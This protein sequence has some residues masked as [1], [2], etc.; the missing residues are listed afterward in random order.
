MLSRYSKRRVMEDS[1]YIQQMRP[2][3]R[4]TLVVEIVSTIKKVDEAHR[5]K[6]MDLPGRGVS[7]DPQP[8]LANKS[9]SY[10]R[11]DTPPST[12]RVEDVHISTTDNTNVSSTTKARHTSRSPTHSIKAGDQKANTTLHHS[13]FDIDTEDAL[14]GEKVTP[15]CLCKSK[16]HFAPLRKQSNHLSPNPY[17]TAN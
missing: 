6:P 16:Q 14:S 11:H 9:P 13:Y 12:T 15:H 1:S 5:R 10:P 17:K 8:M 3:P 4:S 2:N 7:Y